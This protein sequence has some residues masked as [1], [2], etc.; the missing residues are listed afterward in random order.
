MA[1]GNLFLGTA[2][3]KLG[4]VVMMRRD[5]EQISRV[6]VRTI[7]NP[8]SDGQ[9][10][11]RNY[12]APVA[13][14]YAP[15]ASCLERSWEGKNRTKSYQAF[16]KA[17]INLARQNGWSAVKGAPFTPFPYKLSEGTLAPANVSYTA[18]TGFVLAGAVAASNTWGAVSA[19]LKS[20]YNLLEG[21]QVTILRVFLRGES[22]VPVYERYFIDSDSAD[23]SPIPNDGT[24]D[25]AGLCAMAVIFSRYENNKWRRSTQYLV[26]DDTALAAISGVA[27]LDAAVKSYQTKSAVPV[28]DVYLNGSTLP[29]GAIFVTIG[30]VDYTFVGAGQVVINGE[31][32]VYFVTDGGERKFFQDMN[33]KSDYFEK[34]YNIQLKELDNITNGWGADAAPAGIAAADIIQVDNSTPNFSAADSFELQEFAVR[35]GWTPT[36]A[37]VAFGL[38]G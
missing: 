33:E 12:L 37:A 23:P 26:L 8:K 28:S 38:V 36:G 29:E 27:N 24:F 35:F 21:D 25:D 13:K 16:L 17:N 6:R 18:G 1:K 9:A 4:D 32:Y 2:T 11:Q 10:A 22:Y 19:A 30:G 20:E 5:G 14:F 3:K 15:L 31:T 7:A 34:Y